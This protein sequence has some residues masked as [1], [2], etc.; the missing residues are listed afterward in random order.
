M[1][2]KAKYKIEYRPGVCGNW[3]YWLYKRSFS[4][5]MFDWDLVDNFIRGEDAADYIHKVNQNPPR[6]Y[7]S[8]GNRL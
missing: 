3:Y 6:Y 5:F 8:N 1:K 7:D 2:M 4:I